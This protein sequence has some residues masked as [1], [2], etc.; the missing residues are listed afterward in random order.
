[1]IQQ[2]GNTRSDK[3]LTADDIGR[4]TYAGCLNLFHTNSMFDPWKL[5][6]AFSTDYFYVKR[7]DSN[8]YQYHEAWGSTESGNSPTTIGRRANG[9]S[10]RTASQVE[11]RHPDLLCEKDGEERLLISCCYRRMPNFSRSKL[12]LFFL[13]PGAVVGGTHTTHAVKDFLYYKIVITPK[14]GLFPARN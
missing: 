14:P 13:E 7:L 3:Q 10:T 5:G 1:M 8:S 12:G 9:V 4:I 6:I 11:A 2:I